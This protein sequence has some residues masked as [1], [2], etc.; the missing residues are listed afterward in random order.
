MEHCIIPRSME[1]GP[2]KHRDPGHGRRRQ[3]LSLTVATILRME[4]GAVCETNCSPT[5]CQI[6][7][8]SLVGLLPP[9]SGSTPWNKRCLLHHHHHHTNRFIDIFFF[10]YVYV[11]A[12]KCPFMLVLFQLWLYTYF[13]FALILLS[14]CCLPFSVDNYMEPRT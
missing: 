6:F 5:C 11:Y 7:V 8:V 12:C 1:L 10:F 2:S 14:C 9:S 3:W 4:C 13:H